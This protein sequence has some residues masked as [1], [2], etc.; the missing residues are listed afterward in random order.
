MSIEKK[1]RVESVL[2]AIHNPQECVGVDGVGGRFFRLL[3]TDMLASRNTDVAQLAQLLR[4]YAFVLNSDCGRQSSSQ[5]EFSN[6]LSAWKNPTMPF[7]R[8]I[9][10]LGAFGA[11]EVEITIKA[12]TADGDYLRTLAVPTPVVMQ[13][14]KAVDGTVY[15]VAYTGHK[16]VMAGLK[17]AETPIDEVPPK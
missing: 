5:Q 7:A 2:D 10:S 14:Q 11:T 17:T 3:A 1:N 4:Q 8:M 6:L 13:Q 12:K 15:H 16:Q 9:Q